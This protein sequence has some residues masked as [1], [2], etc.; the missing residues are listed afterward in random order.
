MTADF[1]Y[2]V[3]FSNSSKK[4]SINFYQKEAFYTRSQPFLLAVLAAR[5][6]AISIIKEN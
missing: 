3:K 6:G 4:Y 5:I 2:I 1:V